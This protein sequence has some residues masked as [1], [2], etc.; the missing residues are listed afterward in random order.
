MELDDALD[1]VVI[2]V[3]NDRNESARAVVEEYARDSRFQV[4]YEVEPEQGISLARNRVIAR[5]KGEY[6][7]FVDDDEEVATDWLSRLI[8]AA[9]RYNADVVFGPVYQIIPDHAPAW[10]KA[11]SFFHTDS[12]TTGTEVAHGATGNVLIRIDCI[13]RNA[14]IFSQDYGLTGGEDVDFFYRMKRLG[15][16]LIW[17]EEAVAL[18]AVVPSR[19]KLSW[20]LAR[21]FRGGQSVARVFYRSMSTKER[22]IW[23]VKRA[24][25]L[26]YIPL[27][28][29]SWVL[30]VRVWARVAIKASGNL[31]HLT[32]ITSYRYQEYADS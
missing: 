7:T 28:L 23:W 27:V 22:A 16:K 30:G 5:A 21:A 20:L 17:C 11:G 6:L 15:A 24:V 25:G 2:I 1:I 8:G 26:G 31:G 3:D 9:R 12:R 19:L 14:L 18:E 29:V 10:I 13:L 4:I 32:G